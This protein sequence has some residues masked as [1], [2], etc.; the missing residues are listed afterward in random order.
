MRFEGARPDPERFYRAADI[1]VQPSHFEA[2]GNTA[3]EAM[4]SGLAVVSSG[5]G[6]L[7]DFCI[8]N[9]NAVLS[10]PRSPRSVAGAIEKL[11]G[12]SALRARLGAAAR[13]TAVEQFELTA[14]MDR[15]AALIEQVS[16][17]TPVR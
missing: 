1:F 17:G 10:E 11:L 5:V 6:G 12:D 13:T 16:Q 4:A 3:I 2:L 9:V 7:A 8:D 14:L 15:Y